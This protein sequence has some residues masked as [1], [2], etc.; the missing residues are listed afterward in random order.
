MNHRTAPI[1]K[2]YHPIVKFGNGFCK[3][4]SGQTESNF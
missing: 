3:G 4:R 2:L 1:G